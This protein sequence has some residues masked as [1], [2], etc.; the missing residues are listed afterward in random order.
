MKSIISILLFLFISNH[1]FCQPNEPS[2]AV[3]PI[4]LIMDGSGSMWGQINGEAKIEIARKVVGYL[5]D[6]LE[7]ER[8]I[9]LVTYGHRQKGIV[10]I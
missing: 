1:S 5:V 10:K 8:P 7:E 9:G 4:I 3:S 2:V 6:N